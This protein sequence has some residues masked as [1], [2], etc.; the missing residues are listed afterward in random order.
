[1]RSA[2]KV[3]GRRRLAHP[4]LAFPCPRGSLCHIVSP[5]TTPVRPG[6]RA[7]ALTAV[8]LAAGCGL[9]D[10]FVGA[11]PGAVVFVWE[12]DSVIGRDEV[13]PIRVTVLADG[14]PLIDPRLLITVADTTTIALVPTGD[15]LVGRRSGRADVLVELRSSLTT[16]VPS[17]TTV[18]IRVTGATPP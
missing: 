4:D 15:S 10:V 9:T 13:V 6:P 7:A 5:P 17:D 14:E 1:M 2:H 16:G 8:L 3:A 18:S 12:G 11:G